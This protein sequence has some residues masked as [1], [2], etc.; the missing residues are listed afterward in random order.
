MRIRGKM[1]A[2]SLK[3]RWGQMGAD[4]GRWGQMR[5]ERSRWDQLSRSLRSGSYAGRSRS[6]FQE[7]RARSLSPLCFA[8][9]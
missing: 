8:L 7:T 2:D 1:G 3:G 5:A 4:G 6:P 9:L